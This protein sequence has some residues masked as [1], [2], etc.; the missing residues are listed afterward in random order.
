MNQRTHEFLELFSK[1]DNNDIEE[2]FGDIFCEFI[3]EL[4]E[5]DLSEKTLDNLNG[6]F[7]KD[8]KIFFEKISK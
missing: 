5:T 7:K 8:M 4:N 3:N 6:I 2:W 1:Y